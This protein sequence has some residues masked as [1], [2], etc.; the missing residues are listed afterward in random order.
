MTEKLKEKS[1]GKQQ[2]EK[3]TKTKHT[4]KSAVNN[5][6]AEHNCELCDFQGTEQSQL[7]R[8]IEIKHTAFCKMCELQNCAM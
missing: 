7:N 6:E 3:H 4:N 5:K 2:I 8:H 1:A